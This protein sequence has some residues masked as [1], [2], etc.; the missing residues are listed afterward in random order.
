MNRNEVTAML[1]VA[2]AATGM[3]VTD[4]VIS[5]W[6]DMLTDIS[7]QEAA[8]AMRSFLAEEKRRPTIADIRTRVASQHTPAIDAGSAWGEVHRQ[9]QSVGAYRTPKFTHP[10]IQQAV[11]AIGWVILCH[12][13]E[14]QLGTLRAQ[15]ERYLKAFNERR[16]HEA[17]V[18][19]L[20]AA[21]ERRG[22]LSVG[23]AVRQLVG[24]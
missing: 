23:D 14:D 15:F 12:T 4:H 6:T 10:A 22:A 9:V 16:A 18:G 21:T 13:H 11:D 2:S 24:K 5:V 17:N 19:Q 3:Q 1:A 7:A 20:E 8:R